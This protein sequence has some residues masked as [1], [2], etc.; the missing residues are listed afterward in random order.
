MVCWRASEG[1]RLES[2]R[3]SERASCAPPPGSSFL[4]FFSFAFFGALSTNWQSRMRSAHPLSTHV[5]VSTHSVAGLPLL[6]SSTL[7]PMILCPHRVHTCSRIGHSFLSCRSR[8][9]NLTLFPHPGH[10][11]RNDPSSFG[12]TSGGCQQV[13]DLYMHSIAGS[14][15]TF[16]SF[17]LGDNNSSRWTAKSTTRPV[18]LHIGANSQG[19]V[20]NVHVFSL[21]LCL[22]LYRTN[23]PHPV[24]HGSFRSGHAVWV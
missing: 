7:K 24:E 9:P 8:S 21:C 11:I 10:R 19:T 18:H 6:C 1:G 20:L 12:A 15:G 2:L 13:Y 3:E 14:P 4:S 22:S 5:F 23:S 16:S 17:S